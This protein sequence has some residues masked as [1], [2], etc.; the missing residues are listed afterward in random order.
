MK[1]VVSAI[2]SLCFGLLV[3]FSWTSALAEVYFLKTAVNASVPSDQMAA[4]ND[5]V[6]MAVSGVSGVRLVGE[7]VEASAVLDPQVVKIGNAYVLGLTKIRNG[8]IVFQQQA[9]AASLEDMD[10]VAVRVARATITE[11]PFKSDTRV[12]DVT[13]D[14]VT[15]G[16][17][18]K[19][20]VNQWF[21][22]FGPGRTTHMNS[23]NNGVYWSFGYTWGMDEHFNLVIG[24][25][26]L[27]VR[28]S[29]SYIM[30]AYVGGDYHLSDH[31]TS[32]Y[33]SAGLG[34]G[35]ARAHTGGGL[36]APQTDSASGW[37][38]SGGAGIKFFRASR[39]NLSLSG[40]YIMVTEKTSTG[41]PSATIGAIKLYF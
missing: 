24:S 16:T 11:R 23:D 3:I 14:Q 35:S 18:R 33:L 6:R 4:I 2:V 12:S 7:E 25:E 27:K 36:L 22:G 30:Q 13:E 38:V 34:Y 37:V 40:R 21:I 39:V 32:P 15:R 5:L 1:R 31:S 28:D 10:T 17:R 8:Q 41:L 9:R 19:E 29:N 20:T 26:L